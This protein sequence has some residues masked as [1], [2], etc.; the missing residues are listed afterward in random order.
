M[1]DKTL[2]QVAYEK[3]VQVFARPVGPAPATR[4]GTVG[5]HRRRRHRGAGAAQ[6]GHHRPRGRGPRG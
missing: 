2:G 4:P 3:Y 5:S 6:R 1:A